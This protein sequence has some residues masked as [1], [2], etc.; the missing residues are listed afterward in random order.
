LLQ[1]GVEYRAT[2]QVSIEEVDVQYS[3]SEEQTFPSGGR[4]LHTAVDTLRTPLAEE[5]KT[6]SQK[7][8]NIVRQLQAPIVRLLHMITSLSAR[9]P[10][11][12]IS[13]MT[14]L[15][16][17]LLLVGFLTNFNIDVEEEVLWTP[18]DSTAKKHKDW[19][20]KDS[21]FEPEPRWFILMFHFD[22][23]DVLGRDQVQ[24]IFDVLDEIRAVD[25]YDEMCQ[26]S[27]FIDMN[28]VKTCEING[29]VQ[30]WNT[31]SAVFNAQISSDEDAIEQLSAR[32]FPALEQQEVL[33]GY[34][35]RDDSGILTSAQS[36]SLFIRFPHAAN[37]ADVE[38]KALDVV[39]DLK[40]KHRSDPS[41]K[42]YIEV[43]A[44]R[45]FADEFT[46]SIISDI[47]LGTL[48]K[49]CHICGIYGPTSKSR[50]VQFR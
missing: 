37:A 42:I 30:F 39:L 22:G 23:K 45:S 2:Y 18:R 40:D 29:A 38:E 49:K 3:S 26:S 14:F 16:F 50:F 13:F 24:K 33:F 35:K 43:A 36:Y 1:V 32:F 15:S 46:R 5:T 12:T 41:S 28:G 31:S 44:H 21:G 4:K 48:H 8:T 17:F 47:P 20:A 27:N 11:R 6:L 9:N 25:G 10:K 7:W 19:I 34:P